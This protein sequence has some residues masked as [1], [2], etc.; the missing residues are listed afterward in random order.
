MSD[1]VSSVGRMSG[2]E[3]PFSPDHGIKMKE[4]SRILNF[5]MNA[6]VLRYKQG[7]FGIGHEPVSHGV[8]QGS[9]DWKPPRG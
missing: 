2:S 8:A 6:L 3:K 4:F 9:M 7:V 5:V 1:V